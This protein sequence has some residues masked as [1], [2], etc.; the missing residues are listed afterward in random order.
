MM[1]AF[2]LFSLAIIVTFAVVIRFIIFNTLNKEKPLLKKILKEY[3]PEYYKFSKKDPNINPH[4]GFSTSDWSNTNKGKKLDLKNLESYSEGIKRLGKIYNDYAKSFEKVRSSI[5]RVNKLDSFGM[6]YHMPFIIVFGIIAILVDVK[7]VT[8]ASMFLDFAASLLILFIPIGVFILMYKIL[9]DIS[10]RKIKKSIHIV[11]DLNTNSIIW[12]QS[13]IANNSD[14]NS[15]D[16]SDYI[17]DSKHHYRGSEFFKLKSKNIFIRYSDEDEL[18]TPA[19]VLGS[20]I[21]ALAKIT[22]TKI[23]SI[24]K[25]GDAFWRLIDKYGYGIYYKH[26][27]TFT[28]IFFIV[29]YNNKLYTI[30]SLQ[31][32]DDPGINLSSKVTLNCTEGV[33]LDPNDGKMIFSN[34]SKPD[35]KLTYP[36]TDN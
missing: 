8:K 3:K 16:W 35:L 33:S 22:A 20:S 4:I 18:E 1:L 10:I 21:G 12:I 36:A 32:G 14:Y 24:S 15:C 5:K 30:T 23:E 11:T 26:Y 34:K 27:P 29:Q 31:T 17:F 6:K 28:S 25:V 2:F 7:V 9:K 19:L 13:D